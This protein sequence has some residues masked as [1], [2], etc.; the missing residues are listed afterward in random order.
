MTINNG[1]PEDAFLQDLKESLTANVVLKAELVSLKSS[2]GLSKVFAYE[3]VS[4]KVIY[5]HWISKTWPELEYEPFVCRNK[6]Q[7]LKLFDSLKVDFTDLQKNVYFF[8]DRDFDDL[9]GR[10]NN[11]TIFMTEK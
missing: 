10:D 3:G 8:T 7:L 11:H 4:D 6:A 9:R 5:S 1:T 2:C